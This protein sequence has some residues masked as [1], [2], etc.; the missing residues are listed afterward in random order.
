MNQIKLE[1]IN[2]SLVEQISYIIAHD[3]KN[4]DINFVT[5]TGAKVTSDLSLAKIYFTV[6][7]QGKIKETLSALK[8]ASGYIRHELRERIEIRQIPELEFVY[9]ES[10]EYGNKIEKIIDKLHEDE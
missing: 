5:I 4:P 3:V 7:D 1:R 2:S 6:L 10:I 8:D 9:D